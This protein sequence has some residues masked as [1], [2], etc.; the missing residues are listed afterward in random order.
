MELIFGTVGQHQAELTGERLRS[1]FGFW[2][3]E[4]IVCSTMTRAIE[5]GQIVSKYLPGVPVEYCP[6]IEEGAPIRPIPPTTTER[7]D[8]EVGSIQSNDKSTSIVGS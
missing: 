1:D 2:N 7:P 8:Y 3:I 5:T 4:R 6:L